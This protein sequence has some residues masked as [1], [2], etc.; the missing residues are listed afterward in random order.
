M[1]VAIRSITRIICLC[2]FAGAGLAHAQ[3]K[4]ALLTAA[5]ERDSVAVNRLLENAD[6]NVNARQPDGT[7]A[8]AW[9]AHWDEMAM[10]GR[11]IEA[12]ADANLAND[13]GVGPLSLACT[14][15]S[16]AMVGKLLAAGA[17]PVAAR[18]S[19]ETPLMTCARTGDPEAVRLLL[20]RGADPD[21]A[22]ARRGQTALMWA[23]EQNHLDA[24][25]YLIEFHANLS[26]RSANGYTPLMFAAQQGNIP[27]ARMLLGAG[28]GINATSEEFGSP[29]VIA[30]ARGHEE[31]AVFLLENGADPNA[32]D[33]SGMT[34][35]HY[36]VLKGWAAISAVPQHLSISSYMFRP[37]LDRLIDKLLE[38]GAD[39]NARVVKEPKLPGS[40][41]RFSMIGATPLFI[42][43]GAGDIGLLR[44]LLERGADPL[45][46]TGKNITALMVAAGLGNIEDRPEQEE[47]AAL[48][49]ARLLLELGVEVNAA[50][51]NGYTALHGAGYIGSERLIE[52]LVANG[53]N[54]N[55]RDSFE[56]T[57]LSIA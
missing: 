45:I 7:T 46:P 49:I 51:E 28:A 21:A 25:R 2:V 50:G 10:V 48:E 29:L 55:V 38:E 26:A 9:A 43:A 24:A 19:G 44:R 42:A 3:S 37:N 6:V 57:P 39:M 33:G 36:S 20:Q 8:L 27:A 23:L 31:F 18:L 40:T 14:N 56:Q 16:A 12:G 41:P 34:P 54:M 30:A 11:L 15:G 1:R 35:L 53:A 47:Q 5:Q 52:L 32:T 4:E 13:Y 22:E 17:D